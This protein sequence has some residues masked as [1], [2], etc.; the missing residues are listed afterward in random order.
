MIGS[1]CKRPIILNNRRLVRFL[2]GVSY[3][4]IAFPYETGSKDKS[5]SSL[6]AKA[7]EYVYES[8]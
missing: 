7:V 8:L 2:F 6:T 1:F 3:D 5:V 4:L